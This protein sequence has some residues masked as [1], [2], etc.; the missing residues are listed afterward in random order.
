MAEGQNLMI[1][2]QKSNI[3]WEPFYK[4]NKV[5]ETEGMQALLFVLNNALWT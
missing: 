5:R 3:V 1:L 2:L 4:D